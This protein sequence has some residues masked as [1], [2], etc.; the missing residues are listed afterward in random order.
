MYIENFNQLCKQTT[1]LHLLMSIEP[2]Q[3][4]LTQ[5]LCNVLLLCFKFPLANCNPTTDDTYRA[6]V[7]CFMFSFKEQRHDNTNSKFYKVIPAA[8]PRVACS[9]GCPQER[10]LQGK[11]RQIQTSHKTVA[12]MRSLQLLEISVAPQIPAA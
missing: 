1:S 3:L 2:K 8:S 12:W 11:S 7:R 5:N 4:T 9:H 10:I 6:N